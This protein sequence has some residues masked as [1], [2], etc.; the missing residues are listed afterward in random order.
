MTTWEVSTKEETTKSV[1]FMWH[2]G[3]LRQ[4]THKIIKIVRKETC[5]LSIGEALNST[6]TEV[7]REVHNLRNKLIVLRC[8]H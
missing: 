8:M 2:T 1:I 5:W 4:Q 6:S 3:G 7:Q